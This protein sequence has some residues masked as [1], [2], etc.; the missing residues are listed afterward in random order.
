MLWRY[1]HPDRSFPFYSS[2][3][4]SGPAHRLGGRD[5]LV[6]AIDR[7]T[8]KAAWTVHHARASRL[9]S[10]RCRRAGLH[11]LERRQAVR[12]RCASGKSVFE[13]E[14]GRPAVGIA[15]RGVWPGRHR[16]AGRQAV[17]PGRGVS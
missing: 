11:R 7:Q 13:F 2:A 16:I 15:R 6:H 4:L 14:A 1:K 17:L 10:G 5:K 12:P 9:V 3:A 8:G